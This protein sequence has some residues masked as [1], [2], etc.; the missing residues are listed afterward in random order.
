MFFFAAFHLVPTAG[1]PEILTANKLL[2]IVSKNFL[3]TL[4]PEFDVTVT[5]VHNL[6]AIA[7][8][9]L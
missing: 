4:T 7:T 2:A 8:F 3:L 5:V 9:F 1:E 6:H